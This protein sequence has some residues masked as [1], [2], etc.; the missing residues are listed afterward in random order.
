MCPLLVA[1]AK[2]SF[3]SKSLALQC[4]VDSEERVYCVVQN[5]TDSMSSDKSSRS[6]ALLIS[7]FIVNPRVNTRQA[8]VKVGGLLINDLHLTIE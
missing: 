4:L 2:Q 8:V 3:V 5:G 6:S 1:Q 7:S